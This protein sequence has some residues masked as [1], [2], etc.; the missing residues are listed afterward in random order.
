MTAFETLIGTDG[1]TALDE[2]HGTTVRLSD[3]VK[4]SDEFTARRRQPGTESMDDELY[5]LSKSQ[6][7]VWLL[8][9]ASCVFGGSTVT[10]KTGWIVHEGAERWQI[11]EPAAGVRAVEDVRGTHWRCQTRKAV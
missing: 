9:K 7:R 10:P 4:T 8:P 3:G 2:M 1:A 5:M 11:W 6:H